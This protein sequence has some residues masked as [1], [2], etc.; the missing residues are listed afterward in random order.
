M[1]LVGRLEPG[2]DL[3][4]LSCH[5]GGPVREDLVVSMLPVSIEVRRAIPEVVK[6]VH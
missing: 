3:W 6:G 5:R 2:A 4:V 1:Q